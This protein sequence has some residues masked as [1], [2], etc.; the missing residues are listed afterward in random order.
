MS[1][2]LRRGSVGWVMAA[3]VAGLAGCNGT[4][5]VTTDP[6]V[7]A[8]EATFNARC[9]ACHSPASLTGRQDRVTNDLG[10]LSATMNGITLTDDEVGDLKA[11]L[12]VQ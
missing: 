6:A 4:A 9:A 7:A 1:R 10:T 12:A 8:G 11:F 3:G 5:G 2:S